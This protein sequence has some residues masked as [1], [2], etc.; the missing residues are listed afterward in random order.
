MKRSILDRYETTPDGKVVIDVFAP[1]VEDLYEN[2]D[3]TAPYHKKDL[4][5][6]LAYYLTEC[7]REIGRVEFVIRFSIG[8]LTAED[9]RKRVRTSIR[10]FFLYQRELELASMKKMLRT[11]LMLFMIGIVV[12]G[13]SVW[14]NY[15]V[16]PGSG[17]L[18]FGKLFAEGLTIAAWVSLWES[19][20]TFLIYWMPHQQ[21]IGLCWRIANA[22]VLF[23]ENAG[24]SGSADL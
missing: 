14:V 20:A 9:L 17:N 7:A 12:L 8:T 19:L 21:Q 10:T 18:F 24:E 3:K 15:L 4:D 1:R 23:H 2:F 5:E 22:Q 6:D 11:S 16:L 13:L